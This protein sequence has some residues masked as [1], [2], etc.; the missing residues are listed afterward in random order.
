MVTKL[1]T[2]ITSN[3]IKHKKE[4]KKFI[5]KIK[6]KAHLER[7]ITMLPFAGAVAGIY[8]KENNYK[9]WLQGNPNGTKSQCLCELAEITVEI[10]DKVINDL[11]QAIKPS[12]MFLTKMVPNCNDLDQ[13]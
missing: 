6:S 7:I 10:L 4:T 8:F 2:E 1:S 12:E 5:A 9:D 3:T 11:P 13:R